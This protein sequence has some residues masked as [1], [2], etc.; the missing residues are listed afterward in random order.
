MDIEA[1]LQ[2]TPVE[3]FHLGVVRRLARAAEIELDAVF[4]RPFVQRPRNEFAAIG[5]LNG[6]W[7]R[8]EATTVEQRFGRLYRRGKPSALYKRQPRLWLSRQPSRR[9][10]TCT[11]Q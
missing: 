11:R 4:V 10:S 2:E 8:A 3:A 9:R 6:D 5:D 7:Q 1:L